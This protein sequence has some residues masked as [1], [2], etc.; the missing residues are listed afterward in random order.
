MSSAP[1]TLAS[2]NHL[3]RRPVTSWTQGRSEGMDR[4]PILRPIDSHKEPHLDGEHWLEQ[5]TGCEDGDRDGLEWEPLDL[6][7]LPKGFELVSIALQTVVDDPELLAYQGASFILSVGLFVSLFASYGIPLEEP[8]MALSLADDANALF[9]L[10]VILL[11]IFF[12]SSFFKAASIACA[13]MRLE[14]GNPKTVDGLKLAILKTPALIGWAVF[15][16]AV[17]LLVFLVIAAAR[18]GRAKMDNRL[19]SKLVTLRWGPGSYLVVPVI[20]YEGCGPYSA[21]NRSATIVKRTW[22]VSL[23]GNFGTEPIFLLLALPSLLLYAL[24]DW[25]AGH[26]WGIALMVEYLVGLGIFRATV[27]A[28]MISSVYVTAKKNQIPADPDI[29]PLLGN[30]FARVDYAE[31]GERTKFDTKDRAMMFLRR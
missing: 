20:L 4:L 6:V 8:E 10:F 26:A 14:G 2:R 1:A 7:G 21:L 12:V 18:K 17:G 16:A 24:G 13:T 15:S 30:A 11:V 19:M 22:N 9:S 3:Y 5:G 25:Y 31:E 28:V 27:R 29:Y 23:A